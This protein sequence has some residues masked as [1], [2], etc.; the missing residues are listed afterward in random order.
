MEVG[1]NVYTGE[2]LQF[3]KRW[4]GFTWHVFLF[5]IP[6]L[7]YMNTW[8]VIFLW[9]WRTIPE[10]PF[11]IVSLALMELAIILWMIFPPLWKPAV[12]L[13][14]FYLAA[15]VP[16]FFTALH[17]WIPVLKANSVD[18]QLVRLD[19]RLLGVH[20]TI[21]LEKMTTP[22]LTEFLQWCYTSF[23]FWPPLVAITLIWQKRWLDLD[24]FISLI[25]SGFYIS[26]FGYVLFPALGP[27]FYLAHLQTIPLRGLWTF[28]WIQ[29]VLN[30]LENIQWDAFPSGHTAVVVLI[31][32]F[33]YSRMRHLFYVFLPLGIFLIFSTVYLR[34]HYVVDVLAGMVLAVVTLLFVY[35]LMRVALPVLNCGVWKGPL[36]G[37]VPSK[38]PQFYPVTGSR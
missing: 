24:Y 1:G 30:S 4:L 18:P 16:L 26:Y 33:V 2:R 36:P 19:A 9:R 38:T 13:R 15:L 21:F 11:Y 10:A 5:D 32:I 6:T 27:R 34:Y 29:N 25:S 12:L 23:Y 8:I 20:P 31:L 7:I 17:Y 28:H 14:Y 3:R 35:G 22:L 37:Q